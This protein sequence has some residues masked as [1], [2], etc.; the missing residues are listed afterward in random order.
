[1][2]RLVDDADLR[3]RFGRS[4]RAWVKQRY[5]WR[6]CVQRMVRTYRDV[7]AGAGRLT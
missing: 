4:G 1:M 2:Q 3:E 6:G 5:E 7:L